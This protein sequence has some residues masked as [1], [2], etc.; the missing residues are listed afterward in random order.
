MKLNKR[1][2]FLVAQAIYEWIEL[3]L[4]KPP[5]KRRMSD[6]CDLGDLLNGELKD[7]TRLVEASLEAKANFLMPD[8]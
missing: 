3:E 1:E 7:E 6:V 8:K 5:N 2:K 4:G